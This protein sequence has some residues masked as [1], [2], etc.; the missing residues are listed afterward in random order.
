MYNGSAGVSFSGYKGGGGNYLCMP[1]DPDYS[2]EYRSGVQGDAYMY[3]VEYEQPV[4]GGTY[5]H[6][7]VC[8]VC[9]ATTRETVLMIPAK[10][11]CPSSWTTEYS[12]Y[13]VTEGYHTHRTTFE[14]VERNPD[15][16][17][18]S[19]L[20]ADAGHFYH[21]EAHCDTSV[22]CPPYNDYNELTCVVCT[23]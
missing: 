16:V 3:G 20:H 13:L 8:A 7:A 5:Q 15:S 22:P 4:V 10:T 19:H 21:I 6:N 2:F 9:L 18:G 17:P 12:G 14:C 23:K 11:T 1:Q